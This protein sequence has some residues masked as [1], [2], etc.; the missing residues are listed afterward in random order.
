M[1]SAVTGPVIASGGVTTVEDIAR[2]AGIPVDG[3]IIGMALY[4]GRLSLEDAISA[5]GECSHA[6]RGGEIE[7]GSYQ[8]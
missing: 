8:G 1:R 6:Q 7:H 5:S 4:E 2:L 3:C